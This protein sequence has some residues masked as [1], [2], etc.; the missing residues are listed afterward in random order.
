MHLEIDLGRKECTANHDSSA[1]KM[2][3]D[4]MVEIFK[5]FVEKHGVRYASCTGDDD[6]KT[7]KGIID[8]QPT[9][10]SR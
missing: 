4:G 6:S 10:L 2:E 5:R 3:V 9:V 8:A 7:F 1:G